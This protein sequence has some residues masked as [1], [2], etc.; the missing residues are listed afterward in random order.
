MRSFYAFLSIIL[1]VAIGMQLNAQPNPDWSLNFE[2]E[3]VP[4]SLE[5][6][7]KVIDS[8]AIAGETGVLDYEAQIVKDDTISK[9]AKRGNVIMMDKNSF[10]EIQNEYLDPLSDFTVSLWF[11]WLQSNDSWVG[12]V[13]L[14]GKNTN[15]RYYH[16]FLGAMGM[17]KGYAD[18]RCWQSAKGNKF[19][20]DGDSV[21]ADSTWHHIAFSHGDTE[22]WKVYHNG[23][24]AWSYEN[25]FDTLYFFNPDSTWNTDIVI[26]AKYK[27][28]PG[29]YDYLE[30]NDGGQGKS[31]ECMVDDLFFYEEVLKD[32]EVKEIY[33]AQFVSSIRNTYSDSEGLNIFPNPAS[34]SISLNRL[35]DIQI[36]NV[37]GQLEIELDNV[38]T[39]IDISSLQR[40]IYFVRDDVGNVR[41]LMVE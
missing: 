22:G 15:D 19:F 28:S 30:I 9:G 35:S 33:D 1:F 10:L 31:P 27:S 41:K 16:D 7:V 13:Q 37:S 40:G 3:M 24:L 38:Y 6:T 5:T 29:G 8:A 14:V 36:Y 11:N 12:F 21:A 34:R 32:S 18:L 4:A 20:Y 23:T 2:T 25:K 26:G 39:N 17:D